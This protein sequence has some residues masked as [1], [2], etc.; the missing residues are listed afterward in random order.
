MDRFFTSKSR[1]ST[2]S[3]GSAAQPARTA[4]ATASNDAARQGSGSAEQPAVKL[5]CLQE[6]RRWLA[7]EEVV[8]SNLDT[9][10]V[11]EAVA[12]LTR[13]PRPR[14]Q[15]V[16]PLQNK[17]GV[18]QQHRRKRRPL[19]EVIS[20]CERKVV[21]AAQKLQ[22]QLASNPGKPSSSSGA[23]AEQPACRVR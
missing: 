1:S 2:A 5:E 16:Q 17:W 6:V 19:P 9:G 10:P 11:R 23:G 13:T 3:S 7:T 18:A 20:E 21:Q 8:S 22:Q 14:Q 4:S 12:V 15:E